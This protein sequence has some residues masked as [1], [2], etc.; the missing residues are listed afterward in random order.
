MEEDY[1]SPKNKKLWDC[2]E[3]ETF[4]LNYKKE[5]LNGTK[6]MKAEAGVVIFAGQTPSRQTWLNLWFSV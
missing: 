1:S 6:I 4:L 5:H 2:E 3:R